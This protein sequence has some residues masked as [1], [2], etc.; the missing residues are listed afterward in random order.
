[1]TNTT[2]V[3]KNSSSYKKHY[4]KLTN[5][6]AYNMLPHHKYKIEWIG[7]PE[8]NLKIPRK[9]KG[10]YM[11][12]DFYIGASYHIRNRI[13]Q[14]LSDVNNGVPT[15]EV[16]DN[17]IID[18]YCSKGSLLVTLLDPDPF[19]ERYYIENTPNLTNIQARYYD[20][21]YKNK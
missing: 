7:F 21:S 8:S 9:V 19:N 20:Q 1:M 13:L 16:K 4:E 17:K 6:K 2:K 5:R 11:L 15:N 18:W 10:V 3:L 12:G 14:H